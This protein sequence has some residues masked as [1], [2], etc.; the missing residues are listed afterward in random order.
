MATTAQIRQ[1]FIRMGM[2]KKEIDNIRQ[3]TGG[4]R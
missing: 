3:T 1:H 4:P 2:P